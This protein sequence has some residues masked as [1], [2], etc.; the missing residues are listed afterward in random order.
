MFGVLPQVFN[1]M[2]G[3]AFVGTVFFLMVLLAAL[4]SSISLMETV[5]A[6]IQDRWKLGRRASCLVVLGASIILGLLSC[7]GYSAWSELYI[8]GKFQILDFFDF[9][10]NSVMMPIIA[11]LTCILVGYIIDRKP[12][13]DEIYDESKVKS[14]KYFTMMLRY[15]VPVCLVVIL[16]FSILEGVGVIKV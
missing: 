10:T 14:R 8:F 12:I 7:L 6:S 2:F 15:V 4:T 1:G 16:V 9:I 13:I 3:G 5:V 11:L